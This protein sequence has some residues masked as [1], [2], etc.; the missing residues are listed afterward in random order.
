MTLENTLIIIGLVV[1]PNIGG[2]LGSFVVRKNLKWLN[3]C[4]RKPSLYPPTFLFA[5]V[6]LFF[7]IIYFRIFSWYFFI[8]PS[9]VRMCLAPWFCSVHQF[10]FCECVCVHVEENEHLASSQSVVLYRFSMVAQSFAFQLTN[11]IKLYLKF[12][13]IFSVSTL[14]IQTVFKYW[15]SNKNLGVDHPL[16]CHRLRFLFSLWCLTSNYPWIR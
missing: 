5:P 16:L 7:W 12:T 8:V 2:L 4:V 1:F 14:D 13:C 9:I 3:Q 15:W 6:L 10:F 11:L